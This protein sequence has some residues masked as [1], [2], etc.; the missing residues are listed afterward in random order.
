LETPK[1]IDQD[2]LAS[3]FQI[4]FQNFISVSSLLYTFDNV[5]LLA[6]EGDIL[7]VKAVIIQ[8]SDFFSQKVKN[9]T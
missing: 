8:N 6:K 1:R 2:L 3:L 7:S 4:N 5:T 9:K